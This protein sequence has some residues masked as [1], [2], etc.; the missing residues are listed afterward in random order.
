MINFSVGPVMSSKEVRKIAYQ[1]VPYFRTNEFSNIMFENEKLVKKFLYCFDDSKVVFL[2]G[3]GTASMD[4][5]VLNTLTKEDKILIVNGGSFGHRFCE[6]CDVYGLNYTE[7]K[8]EFGKTL[9][10]EQLYKYDDKGYTALLV[11]LDETST[12]VLYDIEMISLF[13]KKN[14]IF[15]IVDSISSFLCDSFNMKELNVNVVL[16]GSQKA[17]AVALG[18]SII[19]LD[20]KALERINKNKVVAYYLD[21][22]P[23]LK[24]MERGQ[25]PFTP[26]VGILLQLNKRLKTIDENGGVEIEISKTKERALYFRNAIKDLPFEI[27]P[28]TM[29]NAVTAL[30]LKNKEKSAYKVFETLKDEYGI[31]ICPNGGELKDKVFRVGHIGDLKISDYKKL[32]K[33]FKSLQKRNII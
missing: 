18:V 14:N 5:A 25:T 21:L 12:G 23:Y 29:S 15:L 30:T 11:N 3:S 24:N 22:K 4:A 26:A 17:L 8:C 31:W 2:T 7:I 10:K 9:T 1:Q 28:D 19:A 20:N 32:I 33:A 16:T 6:I 27:Y 13:C